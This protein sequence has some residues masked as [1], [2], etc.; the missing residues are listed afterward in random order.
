M[1]KRR[2]KKRTSDVGLNEPQP[3]AEDV[4]HGI[5][6]AG[7]T[8]GGFPFGATVDEW[9]E[10][11]RHD[12]TGARWQDAFDVLARFLAS[13][14][15]RE[16]GVGFVRF[17]GSGLSWSTFGAECGWGGGETK[18]LVARMPESGAN[19]GL[20]DRAANERRLLDHLGGLPIPF[21]V[22]AIHMLIPL[23]GRAVACVQELADGR[24]LDLRAGRD[25]DDPWEV[26]A[27][28]AAAVHQVPLNGLSLPGPRTRRAACD[29]VIDE[30]RMLGGP[31]RTAAMAWVDA[32]LPPPE[33]GARL[34][35]GDLL[36]QNLLVNPFEPE[37]VT[38]IDWEY[39]RLGDPAYDLAVV[40]RGARK[41]FQVSD[42]LEKL[43]EAYNKRAALALDIASVRIHELGLRAGFVNSARRGGHV[44][45]ALAESEL[46]AFR[47]L[48]GRVLR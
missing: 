11:S 20:A 7:E 38:V 42:G 19:P 40:T 16:S 21:H 23:E 14:G 18:L 39:A 12:R 31:E 45:V 35:H 5:V 2:S 30:L 10:S 17:L 27:S 46:Q 3:P 32:H 13:R 28:V 25:R 48:L 15:I 29:W 9:R 24:P 41:P 26:V 43:L 22:P 4:E 36:G 33:Q 44:D 8:S 1:A 37:R 6:V 34:I 47:S